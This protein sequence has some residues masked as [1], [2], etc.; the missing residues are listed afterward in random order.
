MVKIRA[1]QKFLALVLVLIFLVSTAA[2]L[3][4]GQSL[5]V[6][7]FWSFMNIIGA[8]FPPT[9]A[10]VDTQS[11]YILFAATLDIQGKLIITIILTT[12]FYQMLGR[13]DIR[14]R[15]V[16]R[17]MKILANHIIIVPMD[18]I[19]TE[20]VKKLKAKKLDFI[21]IE[22]NARMIKKITDQDMLGLNAD[23]TQ[24]EVLEAAGIKRASYLMILDEDDVK[25]TLIAIE[26]KRL[27]PK[28]RIIARI[29]RQDD[30]ARMKR[31]G[32]SRLILPEQAVGNE[33]A[34]FVVS[35]ATKSI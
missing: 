5:F 6:S 18:G 35:E 12:I 33:I 16:E 8:D 14:Q 31:A 9:Q 23:P 28:I 22:P 25:N 29:K 3:A 10:L 20:M 2:A 1:I 24:P 19:A 17:K 27:N 13:I 11:I 4:D 32:I 15:V 26:A 34:K 21:V 7:I 30:I